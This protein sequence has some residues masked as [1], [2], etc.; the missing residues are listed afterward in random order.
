MS[1]FQQKLNTQPT[2]AFELLSRLFDLTGLVY[3]H[4]QGAPVIA[5]LPKEFLIFQ[6]SKL[7][8]FQQIQFNQYQL[9]SEALSL[10]EFSKFRHSTTSNSANNFKGGYIGFFSYDYSA[11]QFTTIDSHPQPSFF[12]GQYSSFLKHENG[13]WQFYSD[14]DHAESIYQ[15]IS[16]LVNTSNILETIAL[17]EKCQ[18][19]WSKQQYFTAFDQVQEYIKAGDCYQINLTQEFT[20]NVQ[21]SLLSSAH[22]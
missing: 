14:E 11:D 9:K 1:Y 7:Q 5:F 6:Q 22:D 4:D 2:S 20:A 18:P 15:Q 16:T 12:L 3:L 19:R 10:I 17:N 21:G 8:Q 13:V